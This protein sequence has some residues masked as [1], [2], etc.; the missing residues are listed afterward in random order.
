MRLAA[1][2][3]VALLVSIMASGGAR[4]AEH[5]GSGRQLYLKYC[6]ACHGPDAKGDGIVASFMRVKPADLTLISARHGGEFP[7]DQV[8]KTIDGRDML[9][10]HGEPAMPVWGDIL[11]REIGGS[12]SRRVPVERRVQGRILTIAEYLESIQ[13]K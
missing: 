10:A 6:G 9:R 1:I 8:V 5:D 13:A 11:S 12:T 7:L 4:A 2:V 3:G